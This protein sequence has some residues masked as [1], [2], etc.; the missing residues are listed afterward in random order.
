MRRVVVVA[1]FAALSGCSASDDQAPI[2]GPSGQSVNRTKCSDSS[3]QCFRSAN[4]ACGG[5]YQVVD[6]SSNAGGVLDDTVP[7][8]TTW[9][10]M[11]YVCGPS[12]GRMPDFP[13]RGQ[14]YKAPTTTTC[15]EGR[16]NSVTCD[17]Y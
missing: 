14:Q 8:P 16:H 7:G 2:V 12:D 13:F 5:S 6:S 9:Y 1:L 11:S 17:T 10:R 3:D 15:R 4:A